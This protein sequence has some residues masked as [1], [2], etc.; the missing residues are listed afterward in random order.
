MNC[1]S[2]VVFDRNGKNIYD[3]AGVI[4]KVKDTQVYVT[5]HTNNRLDRQLN[6]YLAGRNKGTNHTVIRVMP[7]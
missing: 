3:H 5:A 4:T 1:L 6:E 2:L 7:N